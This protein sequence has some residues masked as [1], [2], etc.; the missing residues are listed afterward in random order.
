MKLIE[1]LGLDKFLGKHVPG[2]REQVHGLD[3]DDPGYRSTNRPIKPASHRRAM[4]WKNSL[5]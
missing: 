3:S 4:V 2:G 5:A 1:K